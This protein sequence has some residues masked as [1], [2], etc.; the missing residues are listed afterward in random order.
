[1]LSGRFVT[2]MEGETSASGSSSRGRARDTTLALGTLRRSFPESMSS[3][4][5]SEVPKGRGGRTKRGD[6]GGRAGGGRTVEIGRAS[7]RERV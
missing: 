7:C 4:P 1:M 2:D 3:P 5:T 6:R